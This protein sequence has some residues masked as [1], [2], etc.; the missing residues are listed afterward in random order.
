MHSG[1]L[2][3]PL[4]GLPAGQTIK[5]RTI[6]ALPCC[7]V[8]QDGVQVARQRC[9]ILR[10][11]DMFLSPALSSRIGHFYFAEN[12]TFLLW[13]DTQKTVRKQ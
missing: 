12:R 3:L 10:L 1:F 7:I 11:G 6:S 5:G 8:Y 9:L 2:R 4:W 13:V